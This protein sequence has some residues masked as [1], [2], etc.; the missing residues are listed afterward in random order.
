MSEDELMKKFLSNGVV[1]SIGP[2]NHPTVTPPFHTLSITS[3]DSDIISSN[4]NHTIYILNIAKNNY[5][6]YNQFSTLTEG[7]DDTIDNFRGGEGNDETTGHILI[8]LLMS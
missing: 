5:T 1:S 8:R 3:F 7:N 6:V 2:L 4:N